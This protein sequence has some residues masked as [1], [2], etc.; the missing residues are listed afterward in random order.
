MNDVM[1]IVTVL[2]MPIVTM[3]VVALAL[4]VGFV[5]NDIG[6]REE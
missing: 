3:G 6:D 1:F 5:N 4:I 2:I